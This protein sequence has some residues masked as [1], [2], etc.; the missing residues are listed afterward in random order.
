[1]YGMRS[2]VDWTFVQ[3]SMVLLQPILLFLLA[4]LIFPSSTSPDQNLRS[5]FF[6]QRPWFFGLILALLVASLLKDLARSGAL[7]EA[8][9]VGFHA[10]G[11]VVAG[12]GL[13]LKDERTHR[14]LAYFALLS[15]IAY[16]A[17]LFAEL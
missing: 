10:A 14:W 16:I 11:I 4:V 7:P 2:Y 13:A 6:H 17:V 12:L 8:A 1:M 3:F 15:F 9:N 5:T